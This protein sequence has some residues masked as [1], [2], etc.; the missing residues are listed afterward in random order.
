MY[1]TIFNRVVGGIPTGDQYQIT[2]RLNHDVPLKR[3][4]LIANF[5]RLGFL[6]KQG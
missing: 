5:F 2:V 3:K 6:I 4:S 1:K